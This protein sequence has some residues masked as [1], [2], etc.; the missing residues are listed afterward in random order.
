[1]EPKIDIIFEENYTIM[2]LDGRFIPGGSP[3]IS[4][5]IKQKFDELIKD[6]HFKVLVDLRNVDFFAS[7]TI[8]ALVYGYNVLADHKGKIALWRPKSYIGDSL[9]LVKIDKIITLSDDKNT[10][11][12]GLGL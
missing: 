10:A 2:V 7:N 3:E 12:A 8:G 5:V 11:L 9:R 6:N 4:D 1:M